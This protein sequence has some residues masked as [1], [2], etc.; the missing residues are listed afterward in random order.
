M[1]ILLKALKKMKGCVT[2][3]LM[4]N[5]FATLHYKELNVFFI[6]GYNLEGC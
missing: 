5:H 4:S 3:N 6:K 1:N 2:F